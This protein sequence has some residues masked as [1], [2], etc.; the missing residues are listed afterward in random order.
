MIDIIFYLNVV[1]LVVLCYYFKWKNRHFQ[2]LAAR[3]P[4][5]LSYP[6][7]G[8]GYQFLGSSESNTNFWKNV[9]YH[10][11][12]FFSEIMSKIID[13]TRDYNLEPYRLWIGPYFAVVIVKPEDVQVIP[14][15][16]VVSG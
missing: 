4:G 2:K 16:K 1:I 9:M 11:C 7:I 10:L 3:M 5:P 15:L 6:I 13:Y 14:F 12:I 8:I